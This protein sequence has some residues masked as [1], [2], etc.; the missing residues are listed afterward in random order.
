M[1]LPDTITLARSGAI[2]GILYVLTTIVSRMS[3]T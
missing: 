3:L 2:S 1:T